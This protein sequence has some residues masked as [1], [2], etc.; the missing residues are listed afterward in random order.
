MRFGFAFNP[1]NPQA[2]AALDRAEAWCRANGVETWSSEASDRDRIAAA[3]PGTDLV[4][5]KSTR[6]NSSHH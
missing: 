3:C 2:R 6:L 1:T 5:R 4:D